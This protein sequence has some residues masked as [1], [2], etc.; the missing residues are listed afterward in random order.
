MRHVSSVCASVVS[1]TGSV[2]LAQG[3]DSCARPEPIG[4]LGQFAFSTEGATT[5]GGPAEIC[6][7]F[8][9]A[10]IYNDVWFC[11][12]ADA[13]GLVTISTCGASYDTKL[14]VYGGCAPCPGE[15]SIL[16]CNDDSCSLQSSLSLSVVSGE[17]YTIRVGSY[18]AAVT[19]AGDLSIASGFLADVTDPGSGIRYVA[20]NATTWTAAE[21]LAQSLGGHLTSIGSAEEQNFVWTTFGNLD[22]V[23]RRVWIGFNDVANEGAFEWTDQSPVAFTNWNSGE[24]N[25]ANGTEHYAELLGSNG[26]WND[27]PDNGGSFPHIAVF[28]LPK[29]GGGGGPTP[30]PADLDDNDFV[31]AA[32]LG[33]L[34]G[35]WGPCTGACAADLD[36]N[37]FVDAAD[38][39]ILLGGWGECPR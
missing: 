1:L 3:S 37:S 19:G 32:D 34:L 4:G 29:D 39:G 12:T 38:L 14:A 22:G 23:D 8:N 9:S 36:D 17:S 18:S 21:A 33:I 13:T 35:A 27:M 28:E 20:V 2:A 25:N 10:E 16:A 6:T 30:C 7:F 24:P 26:E 31:D 11:W 15:D 5:D